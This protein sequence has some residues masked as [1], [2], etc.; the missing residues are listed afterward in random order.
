M[1]YALCALLTMH[2]SSSWFGPIFQVF[3]HLRYCIGKA[4]SLALIHFSRYVLPHIPSVQ[5]TLQN[6]YSSSGLVISRLVMAVARMAPSDQYTVRSVDEGLEHRWN[7]QRASNGSRNVR[8]ILLPRGAGKIIGVGTNDKEKQQ[9]LAQ[10]LPS[11][12]SLLTNSQS[13]G[14]W[15]WKFNLDSA[16]IQSQTPLPPTGERGLL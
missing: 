4:P 1:R 13:L 10:I 11:L 9:S 6:S 8:R 2:S 7:R 3:H 12:T 16:Q 5:D 14:A 15:R